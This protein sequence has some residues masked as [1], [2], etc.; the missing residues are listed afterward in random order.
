MVIECEHCATKY[1]FNE[2]NLTVKSVIVRCAKCQ[3]VFRIYLLDEHDM[4]RESSEPDPVSDENGLSI[5]E[6][7]EKFTIGFP[8]KQAE[9]QAALSTA[10]SKPQ[11]NPFRVQA[12]ATSKD[13]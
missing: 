8:L 13:S 12:A 6:W 2:S 10:E 9:E 5:D 7:A 11:V 3:N 1:N 4:L